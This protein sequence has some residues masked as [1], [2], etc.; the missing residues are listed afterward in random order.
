MSRPA[1][2]CDVVMKGAITSGVAYNGPPPDPPVTMRI[3]GR[4]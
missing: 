2:E 3:A 4:I 1:R